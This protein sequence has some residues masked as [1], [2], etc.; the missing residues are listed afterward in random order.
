MR[1]I[2]FP[3]I[4][5]L[6]I[7]LSL[8]PASASTNSSHVDV[9]QVS[10]LTASDMEDAGKYYKHASEHG[11]NQYIL[12]YKFTLAAALL[13]SPNAMLWMGEMYQGGHVPG[14]SKQDAVKEAFKWWEKAYQQGQ[15]R[16]YTNI[17][18]MYLHTDIPG[19]GNNFSTIP[20]D[21]DKAVA[22]LEKATAKNDMKAPR[23]LGLLYFYGKG[24]ILKDE[25]KALGYFKKAME[26]GDS[27][28]TVYYA[29]A[30]LSGH[31]ISKDVNKAISLYQSIIDTNGHDAGLCGFKLGK[32]YET[33]EYVPKDLNKAKFYYLI[34]VKNNNTE[35]GRALS[36]L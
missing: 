29:D 5:A 33:G 19:G 35:A 21:Y 8:L 2:I 10:G 6:C 17:G 1:F 23:N 36:R 16:G 20:V 15:P 12:E 7:A 28:G 4:S 13:G 30:L 9:L 25:L 26:L 27:T 18:L 22:Y 11:D 24:K 34:A 31:L 32:I 14:V 3:A